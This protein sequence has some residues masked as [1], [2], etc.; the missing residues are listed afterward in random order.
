MTMH[1]RHAFTITHAEDRMREEFASLVLIR[2]SVISRIMGF[3][4]P[5]ELRED[6]PHPVAGFLSGPKLR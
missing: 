6:P 3:P 1:D 5:A 4:E 2:Q